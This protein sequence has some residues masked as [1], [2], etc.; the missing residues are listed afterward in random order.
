MM[1]MMMIFGTF[2]KKYDHDTVP[3]KRYH[4][5]VWNHC[6]FFQKNPSDHQGFDCTGIPNGE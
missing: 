5:E 4:S 2:G 6:M 1:M 3:G